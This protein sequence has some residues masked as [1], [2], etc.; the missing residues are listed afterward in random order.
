[1]LFVKSAC[2]NDPENFA[3]CVHPNML[4]EWASSFHVDGE[5]HVN[6][7]TEI[8][9]GQVVDVSFDDLEKI[10]SDPDKP[11]NIFITAA[12]IVTVYLKYYDYIHSEEKSS[13]RE[14]AVMQIDGCWYAFGWS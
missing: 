3:K 1:M 2:E 12:K 6:R 14:C 10:N 9:T 7:V 8:S 5:D 13:V 4:E 11:S